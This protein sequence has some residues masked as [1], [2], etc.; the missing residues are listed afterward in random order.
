MLMTLLVLL[1][2]VGR[3]EPQ[4]TPIKAVPFPSAMVRLSLQFAVWKPVKCNLITNPCSTSIVSCCARL[5]G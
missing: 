3:V 5:S 1:I 4:A 2:S